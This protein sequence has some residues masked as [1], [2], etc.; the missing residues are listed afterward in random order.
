MRSRRVPL[1]A[2]VLVA[3]F[4]LLSLACPA[5]G[6]GRGKVRPKAAPPASAQGPVIELNPATIREQM[7]SSYESLVDVNN[8]TTITR[9]IEAFKNAKTTE[10]QDQLVS[11]L[12]DYCAGRGLRPS[13]DV[14]EIFLTLAYQARAHGN[15]EAFQRLSRY[16]LSFDPGHPA[17]HLAL[18]SAARSK[19]GLLSGEFYYEALTALFLSVQN[20]ETRWAALANLGLWLRL[21]AFLLLGILALMLLIKYQALLRHDIREWLGGGDSRWVEAAGLI[22]L[23]LPSLLFLS[24]YWWIIYWAG[25]FLVYARWPQRAV[26]LAAVVLFVLSGAVNTLYQQRLYLTAAP[27]NASNLRCYAHRIGVGLDAG[28]VEHIGAQDPLRG[29]YTYLLASRYLL[30]GSYM[31]AENLYQGLLKES[32]DDAG[33]YNNMGCIYYYENRYQEAIQAFT[34]ATAIQPK[35]A[36]AY[37]NRS[38]AENKVFDFSASKTDQDKAGALRAGLLGVIRNSE[39]ED[40]SPIPVWLPLAKTTDI[41]ARLDLPESSLKGP[42]KSADTWAGYLFLPP[43]SLMALVFA[44][45]F[46]GLALSKKPGYFAR[47]CAKCGQPFC[48]RC[49]TSLEFESFCSQCVHLFIRQDGVSPEARI[50]KNYEVE[51]HLKLQ[52][53]QRLVLAFAA[54]GANLFLEGRPYSALFLLF[55]WCGLLVAFTLPFVGFPLPIPGMVSTAP[56]HTLLWLVGGGLAALIWLLFGLQALLRGK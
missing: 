42:V 22:G 21:T 10:D 38:F 43:F 11:E 4:C 50:K 17:V 18:A 48:S 14:A 24:G 29:T 35:L 6:Q 15:M 51:R 54:P 28:L 56:F 12:T 16:A 41:A 2:P 36:V 33:V 7:A 46:L 8:Q 27:P 55:L 1:T 32:P 23:F 34:K 5:L 47:A 52:R 19:G 9:Y 3:A 37:L 45:A 53:V 39:A 30:H 26:I 44:L 25:L 20:L 40:L 13:P 31:K 49:K